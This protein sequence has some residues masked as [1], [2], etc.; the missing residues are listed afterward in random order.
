MA[1]V[2]LAQE[3][4]ELAPPR[5][6]ALVEGYEKVRL[7]AEEDR[8]A[9]PVEITYAALIVAFHR[10]YRHNVRFPDISKSAYYLEMIKFVDSVEGA[11]EVLG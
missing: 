6:K 3:D 1:A 2:G 4:G 11:V 9:L 5:L 10:Y 8:R 7:L